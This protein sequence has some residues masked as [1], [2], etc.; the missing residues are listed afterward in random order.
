MSRFSNL[1]VLVVLVALSVGCSAN[2]GT[3]GTP[4]LVGAGDAGKDVG[5]PGD[6]PPPVGRERRSRRGSPG[7]IRGSGAFGSVTA[8]TSGG[9]DTS[10]AP[11][12]SDGAG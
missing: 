12:G 5:E 2:A 6:L 11:S 10:A 8:G 7:G 4:T 3:G 9:G 1:G